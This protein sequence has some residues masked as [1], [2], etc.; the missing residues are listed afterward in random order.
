MKKDFELNKRLFFKINIIFFL[1]IN[2]VII[3]GFSLSYCTDITEEDKLLFQDDS[4]TKPKEETKQEESEPA[5]IGFTSPKQYI[6]GSIEGKFFYQFQTVKQEK[7]HFLNDYTAKLNIDHA[8]FDIVLFR[9]RPVFGISNRFFYGEVFN[10]LGE[11]SYKRPYIDFNEF[12]AKVKYSYFDLSIGKKIY[13][14]GV[15][16]GYNPTDNITPY[17]ML[18]FLDNEKLGIFSISSGFYYDILSVEAVFIPF[19]TPHRVSLAGSRWYGDLAD[20]EDDEE[21]EDT[22]NRY[23][24]RA[25]PDR[26]LEN[27]EYAGRIKA[28]ISGWDVSA[29]F[30]RGF[31]NQPVAE[32]IRIDDVDHVTP[33]FNRISEYG[34]TISTLFGKLDLHGE[35]S[36]RDVDNGNDENYWAYIG[37]GSYYFD[38]YLDFLKNIMI[39]LEYAGEDITKFKTNNKRSSTYITRPFKNSIV[40]RLEVKFTDDVM[41]N[42]SG[43]YS[44]DFDRN[45]DDV[46]D[47]M[48]NY[49]YQ[50]LLTWKLNDSY[51]IKTG[52]DSMWGNKDS[53]WGRFRNNDRFFVKLIYYFAP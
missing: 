12:Y 38:F 4:S 9:V 53:F 17:D 39:F 15:A 28:S 10:F 1:V 43:S 48:R 37:G 20:H 31:D 52:T 5:S 36:F 24:D 26:T 32:T 8:F 22:N 13:N 25:M 3:D 2:F 35:I 11:T 49:Y 16:N 23:H 21:E 40:G 44:F 19:F 29:C 51:T 7:S 14:W 33:V 34:G 30:F 46:V 42:W 50:V 45:G 41:I 6:N 27:S 47:D 18:D